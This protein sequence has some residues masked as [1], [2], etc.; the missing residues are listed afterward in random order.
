M[1]GYL[2]HT[3]IT[4]YYC[5]CS[6]YL[7]PC[8]EI[9]L[10]PMNTTIVVE[11]Q[12]QFTCE[13]FSFSKVSYKW[14]RENGLLPDKVTTDTCS[15]T[16]TIPNG[17]QFDEGN[18]C[19][20]ATNECGPVKECAVLS[21]VGMNDVYIALYLCSMPHTHITHT[22]SNYSLYHQSMQYKTTCTI[23]S[24]WLIL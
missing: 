22:K 9:S 10:F 6:I 5:T 16:L 15:S 2:L 24:I 4:S 8:P 1:C 3:Y 11:E 19:C 18:Y 14:E 17:T 23:I 20:V 7:V 13:A 21:V 12:A